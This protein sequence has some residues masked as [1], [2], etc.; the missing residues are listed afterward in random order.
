MTPVFDLTLYWHG[1]TIALFLLL[2]TW[3]VSFFKGDV[4]IV[5]S[6]WSLIFLALCASWFSEYE[7]TTPRSAMVM[8][9]VALWA[10]RL[11]AYIDRKS[12]V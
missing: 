8:G 11:S 3:I 6:L 9:L 10:I 5:D 2:L 7:F 4:S 12:V 1:L